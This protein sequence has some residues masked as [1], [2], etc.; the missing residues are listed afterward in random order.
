MLTLS[1]QF[2]HLINYCYCPTMAT[3][4]FISGF[5]CNFNGDFCGFTQSKSDKFDW[6][7][8][9]GSTSSSSTGPSSGNGGS[10]K[11]LGKAGGVNYQLS[12][13]G[14]LHRGPGFIA[15]CRVM[16]VRGR[17]LSLTQAAKCRQLSQIQPFRTQVQE[18]HSSNFLK[19]NVLARCENWQYNHL[20]SVELWKVKF[21]VL[22]DVVFVVRLQGKFEIDHTWE[23]KR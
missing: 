8:R 15:D 13:I 6:T 7:R 14:Y 22:C 5:N 16:V 19:R 12:I 11:D 21:F 10:G 17:E 20:P 23:W 1:S 4:Y 3:S 2:L 18:V 9:S